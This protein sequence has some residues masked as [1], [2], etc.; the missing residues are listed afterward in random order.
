MTPAHG[1]PAAGASPPMTPERWQAVDAILQAALACEPEERA[2]FAAGACGGDEAL[3]IEVASLLAAHDDASDDFL[4]QPAAQT[5]GAADRSPPAGRIASALMERLGNAL[6]GRHAID[7]E[8]AR[9]GMAT[10]YLARDLRHGRRVAIKVLR[11]EVAA[12]VGAERFLA[13]IRVTASLQHPH[14]L[15]LFDSGSADGMLWY[16]MPFVEGETL[17]SRLAREGRLP[18]TEAVRLAREIADALDYAHGQGI[19][20]RD[21]KP[22]NVLLQDGHALVADF[23]IALALEQAG[24]ERLT[25]TGLALGTPQYMAPEQAAGE[26]A[27]DARVDV[28]ALGA[29]LHEMLAGESPFAAPTRQ[30]VVQ[31]LMH[32]EPA[33]LATRRP[34]VAPFVAAAVR[35]ALAKRPDDR[36][37][38]AAAFAAALLPVPTAGAEPEA[39]TGDSGTRVGSR[40]RTVSASAAM[41]V[42]IATLVVGLAGGMLVDPRALVRRWIDGVPAVVRPTRSAGGA[43]RVATAGDGPRA[44]AGDL[45]L[46][47]VDRAG[48]PLRVIPADR[49]WT[50]RFSPDGRR[51]AFGAFGA[52]RQ[53]SDLWVTDLAAGTTQR[54]TDGDA[55]AND[56]QWSSD[57]AALA[58]SANAPAGKDVMMRTLDGGKER[59]LAIRTGTQFPSDWLRD[60]A[61][62][63]TEQAGP[64]RNDI[65]VQPKDG[66]TARPYAATPADESAARISPDGRWVAYTS[67]E[68]GRAEVYIDSYPRPARRATISTGGGVHPVWR[69]DGRELYYWRD[70]ALVAT[71]LGAAAGDAPPARGD[72]TVL[73]RSPYSMNGVS[74]M[75]DASPDGQRFVIVRQR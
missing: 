37:S 72:E 71:Q 75:Y 39:A 1:A 11:E 16:A 59:V 60:G 44:A 7:R 68:S 74:T 49:P 64:D 33:A 32:E 58:Y 26:R 17:R 47:L 25:R 69:G 5:L 27:L 41:Y 66:S 6:G 19:V 13:E 55:D 9:G 34:D 67:D 24:G 38:S 65:L 10:V 63:V 51:V 52:G 30:A 42:A 61:L 62:L 50:P 48:R 29:V 70:G 54:L 57:G 12:A 40:G 22:E 18:L 46:A 73:F 28:Y 23:G 53:T 15:P 43:R 31:R 36:F 2:A 56:P 45:E 8:I 14:I 3:R 21:V 4:E 35:R 20:H